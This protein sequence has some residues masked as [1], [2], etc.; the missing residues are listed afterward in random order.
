MKLYEANTCQTCRY[1]HFYQMITNGTPYGYA[2]EIPCTSCSR[3]SWEKDNYEP[4]TIKG[5]QS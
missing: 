3:F 2:G 4:V 5:N 1:Y